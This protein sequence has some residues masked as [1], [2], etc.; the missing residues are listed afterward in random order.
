MHKV[1][2]SRCLLGERVRFDGNRKGPFP[3]L[4]AWRREGRVVA[5][6]P[7]VA[8]GLPIPRAPSEIP[9]GQGA[10]VLD[11]TRRVVTSAGEDVTDAFVAGARAAL[12]LVEEHGIR[13]AVL[14]ARSPSCGHRQTYDG[15]F[16]GRL[17]DGEGV[18]AALL[19]RHG[20]QVFSEEE[21]EAA[22]AALDALDALDTEGALSSRC[23]P[24]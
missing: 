2:V 6:C 14:K 1:L 7:E 8:G 16:H 3:V 13:I 24:R 22:E 12:A 23:D 17:V 9:G 20:V 19:A 5:V 10:L 15:S 18:T 21:L 11:G 4:D